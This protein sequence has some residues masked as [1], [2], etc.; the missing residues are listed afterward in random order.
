MS[1]PLGGNDITRERLRKIGLYL[2]ELCRR[3]RVRG[4]ATMVVA[5]ICQRWSFRDPDLT[6]RHFAMGSSIAH[7][8]VKHFPVASMV[9]VWAVGHW[10]HDGV[11][12]SEEG[13]A[14]F[15]NSLRLKLGKVL[16][17]K[18]LELREECMSV[19]CA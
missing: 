11:H 5:G 1:R 6:A 4:I 19:A 8:V 16:A 18:D 13:E 3:L 17:P 15:L 2:A 12:L 9:Y 10:S 7:Y 14:E